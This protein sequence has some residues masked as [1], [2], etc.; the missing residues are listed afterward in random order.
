MAI[1]SDNLL[2]RS[3]YLVVSIFL[4]AV[5]PIVSWLLQ[6]NQRPKT[7]PPGPPTIPVLGNLHQMPT[8][9]IFL[10]FA[11]S[12]HGNVSNTTLPGVEARLSDS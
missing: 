1:E 8:K 2:G 12:K 5:V 11:V 10:K 3:P 6:C 9:H 7:F 4:I